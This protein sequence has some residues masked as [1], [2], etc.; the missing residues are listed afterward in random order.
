MYLCGIITFYWLSFSLKI[1]LKIQTIEY[2]IYRY[3]LPAGM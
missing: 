1:D 2:I 3:Q